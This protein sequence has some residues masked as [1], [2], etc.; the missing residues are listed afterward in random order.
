M[1]C[2][3]ALTEFRLATS[4]LL[5]RSRVSGQPLYGRTFWYYYAQARTIPILLLTFF[6]ISNGALYWQTCTHSSARC[7]SLSLPQFHYNRS[8]TCLTP[9]SGNSAFSRT[10]L[11]FPPPC[12]QNHPSPGQASVFLHRFAEQVAAADSRRRHWLPKREG[13]H[14]VGR[15]ASGYLLLQHYHSKE[16]D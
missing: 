7:Y 5:S 13:A 8:R 15:T 2:R 1:S 14:E 10:N 4:N 6:W 12:P 3:K 11:L 9:L 16:G